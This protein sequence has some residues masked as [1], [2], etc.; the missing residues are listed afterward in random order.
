[1]YKLIEYVLGV[2]LNADSIVYLPFARK[3]KQ[4]VRRQRKT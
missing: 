4:I 1:M 2:L 3:K